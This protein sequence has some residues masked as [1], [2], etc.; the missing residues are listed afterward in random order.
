MNFNLTF[1]TAD[2]PL[3]DVMRFGLIEEEMSE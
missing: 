1:T 2:T 3:V